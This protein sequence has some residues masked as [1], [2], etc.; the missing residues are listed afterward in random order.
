MFFLVRSRLWWW[1]GGGVWGWPLGEQGVLGGL[2]S[3]QLTTQQTTGRN[4]GFNWF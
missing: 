4:N 3:L 2:G 1:W